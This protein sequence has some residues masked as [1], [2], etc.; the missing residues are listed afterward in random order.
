[1]HGPPGCSHLRTLLVQ[2]DLRLSSTKS[3]SE[4]I[5][6]RVCADE[7]PTSSKQQLNKQTLRVYGSLPVN[8]QIHSNTFLF[9]TNTL[10][11]ILP[12]PTTKALNCSKISYNQSASHFTS[13]LAFWMRRWLGTSMPHLAHWSLSR[14]DAAKSKFFTEKKTRLILRPLKATT[15]H[16]RQQLVESVGRWDAKTCEDDIWFGYVWI[17]SVGWDRSPQSPG[18]PIEQLPRSISMYN[19]IK[20]GI[21]VTRT[22]LICN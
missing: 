22:C 1:M 17:V 19:N 6:R 9:S 11:N 7:W 15:S 20:A 4:S 5:Y 8:Y 14:L 2:S 21:M 13:A 3:L 18:I 10:A 12:H 16:G